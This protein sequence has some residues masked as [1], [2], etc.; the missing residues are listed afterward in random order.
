[1][2]ASLS[3]KSDIHLSICPFLLSHNRRG[4]KTRTEKK[5]YKNVDYHGTWD[6]PLCARRLRATP[7]SFRRS[8]IRSV[9]ILRDDP[10]PKT[11]VPKL[12]MFFASTL[13]L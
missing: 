7:E 13:D 12:Q 3:I 2:P 11:C 5:E 1:M 10:I 8:A 9:L 6:D 4:K